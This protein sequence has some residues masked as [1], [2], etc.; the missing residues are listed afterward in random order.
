MVQV[1]DLMALGLTRRRVHELAVELGF[2][3]AD[4][5]P[6]EIVPALQAKLMG[7][8]KTKAQGNFSAHSAAAEEYAAAAQEDLAYVQEAAENRAAGML[9]AL[10][11][12][13][14]LHCATRQFSSKKLQRQVNE[15]RNR[16]KQVLSGVAAFYEPQHFLSQTPLGQLMNGESGSTNLIESGESSSSES[17]I[18]DVELV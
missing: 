15:S 7:S 11:D 1:E 4:Q 2:G 17:E 12:L 16:V 6:D 3:K 5:Y 18:A 10:D 14:M 13:T 8:T 9:V